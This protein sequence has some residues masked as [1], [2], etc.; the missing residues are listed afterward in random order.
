MRQQNAGTVGI[1]LDAAKSGRKVSALRRIPVRHTHDLQSVD[2]HLL[3]GQH[4]HT[5]GGN[6]TQILAVV[7]K[8][9]VV[10]RDKINAMWR[11]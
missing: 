9:L 4:P 3:I 1:E 8:L 5:G 2:L 6:R 10:S 11:G 7:P